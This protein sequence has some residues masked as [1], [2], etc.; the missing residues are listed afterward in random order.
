MC[1][2]YSYIEQQNNYYNFSKGGG[3]GRARYLIMISGAI[4]SIYTFI[5]FPIFFMQINFRPWF[6]VSLFYL[7]FKHNCFLQINIKKVISPERCAAV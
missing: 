6:K 1:P 7:Y 3:G 4:Q 2:N 5:N